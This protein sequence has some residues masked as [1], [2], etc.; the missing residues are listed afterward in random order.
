[1]QE[2]PLGLDTT[3]PVPLPVRTVVSDCGGA[4]NCAVTLRDSS[5]LT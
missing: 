2:I 4:V 5:V 1:V 3:V